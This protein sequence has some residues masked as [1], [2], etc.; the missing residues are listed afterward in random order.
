MAT[1]VEIC[2][3]GPDG[4]AAAIGG[5]ASRIELCSAL[6]LGGL[7]PSP[8]LMGL[9]AKAPIPVYAM[10]RPRAGDFVF[11][12]AELDQMRRDIDAVRDA[13]LAGVVLGASEPRGPL[14]AAVLAR[15]VEHAAG[16]GTTLHRAFDAAPD[17]F[18]AIDIAATLGFERILTAG[19]TGPADDAAPRLADYVAH[20]GGRIAIMPGGGVRPGNVAQILA[21]T[22][23]REIHAS[24][25]VATRYEDEAAI[26]LGFAS[27]APAAITAPDE[28][29]ALVAAVRVFDF[30]QR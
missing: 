15:L 2:V 12:P 5:G 16:L 29:R 1:L 3:D 18:A 7:T 10:I 9:A 4:L 19:G 27:P 11:S 25:R 24:C 14:A 13:G 22:D 6:V 20:A 23:A 8:G 17:P 21:A 28:V 26:R 30:A